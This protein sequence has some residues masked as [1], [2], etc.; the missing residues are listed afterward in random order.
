MFLT[1]NHSFSD[2]NF[3]K[4]FSMHQLICF[5]SGNSQNRRYLISIQEDGKLFESGIFISFHTLSSFLLRYGYHNEF[6]NG[7]SNACVP[8]NP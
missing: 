7:A 1:D 8:T 2:L 3:R 6:S 5:G 4:R